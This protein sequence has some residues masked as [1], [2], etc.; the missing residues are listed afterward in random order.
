MREKVRKVMTVL[1]CAVLM[2]GMITIQP[3]AE[4]PSPTVTMDV[5]GKSHEAQA[6]DVLALVNEQRVQAGVEPLIMAAELETIAKQR[7]AE[8]AVFY[9]HMR[10]DGTACFTAAD[11]MKYMSIGENIAMGQPDAANVVDSWMNSEGHRKNILST[12]FTH[13]GIGCFEY[14]GIKHWVQFFM[15]GVSDVEEADPE[16][17]DSIDC[18]VSATANLDTIGGTLAF[19]EAEVTANPGTEINLDLVVSMDGKTM[20]VSGGS[21][22]I[23]SDSKAVTVEDQTIRI[24]A[25]ASGTA[26]LTATA[27]GQT[28]VKTLNIVCEHV[29]GD[30]TTTKEATWEEEGE[31]VRVCANC[32]T[33]ETRV[34]PK[35]SEGHE[36]DFT[37]KETVVNEATCTKE[38]SKTIACANP[39]CGEV[40]TVTIPALGHDGKETT[41]AATCTKDG[42]R[43]VICSRCGAVLETEVIPAIGHV[44]GDW[45]TT[46]EA[47][48]DED[49]METRTCANCQEKETRVLPK[50]SEGHEHDFT[51]KETVVKEAT[52]TEEGSRTIACSNP[53]CK[54]VKTEAIPALGH[55]EKEVVKTATC[56]EKGTKEIVCCR[57]GLILK[58]EIIP[59]E[60]HDFGDWRVV[61]KATEKEEGERQRVCRTC[62]YVEKE[63]LKK[64]EPDD[65][66]KT[67]DDSQMIFFTMSLVSA[68]VILVL[69]GCILAERRRRIHKR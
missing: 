29:W 56:T 58:K 36:H 62:N 19:A 13:I 66:A 30:W 23:S 1:L 26:V 15:G 34:L 37:G 6:R 31:Q 3:R 2:A 14:S 35:L 64:L 10:P 33:K 67:G 12:E 46:K 49:G 4:E 69:T 47:A 53:E 9:S 45:E 59:A 18:T 27:G 8:L 20:P 61:K 40:R 43:E 11:G 65:S 68:A 17:A 55:E 57:C 24:A 16:G 32:Q 39:N 28:A 25:G 60:G 21:L 22:V 63:T 5:A 42:R 7:A 54:E 44:W 38:G 48:W 52:C 50:R 51:G 41:A